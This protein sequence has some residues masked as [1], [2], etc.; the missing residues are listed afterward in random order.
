MPHMTKAKKKPIPTTTPYPT[1]TG[2][3]VVE[4]I[5][6]DLKSQYTNSKMYCRGLEML[7]LKGSSQIHR[8]FCL[9]RS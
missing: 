2:K 4:D 1:P 3:D 6:T 5:R 7:L 9:A 8:T